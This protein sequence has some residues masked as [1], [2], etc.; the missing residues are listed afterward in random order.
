MVHVYLTAIINHVTTS[1]KVKKL[2]DCFD[3]MYLGQ[4]QSILD[5]IPVD[6]R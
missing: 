5:R 2:I 3:W 4:L 6:L 1:T